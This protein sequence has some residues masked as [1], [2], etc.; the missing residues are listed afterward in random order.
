MNPIITTRL[1]LVA[2]LASTVSCNADTAAKRDRQQTVR[3]A[4]YD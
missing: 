4:V 3:Q 1:A 2:V